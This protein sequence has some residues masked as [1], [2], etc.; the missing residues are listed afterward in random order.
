MS[1]AGRRW[2]AVT[3]VKRGLAVLTA[4]TLT[5]SSPCTS[6]DAWIVRRGGVAEGA[7]P[8]LGWEGALGDAPAED[9]RSRRGRRGDLRVWCVRR[10]P[11][12]RESPTRPS[13]EG[14]A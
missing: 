2:L 9:G 8:G 10:V 6:P 3:A 4:V 1:R 11:G 5:A 12:P 7:K 13:G 14:E